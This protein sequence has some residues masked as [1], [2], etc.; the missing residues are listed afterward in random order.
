MA[1]HSLI[2]ILDYFVF[3]ILL[4]LNKVQRCIHLAHFDKSGTLIIILFEFLKDATEILLHIIWIIVGVGHQIVRWRDIVSRIVFVWVQIRRGTMSWLGLREDF[5]RNWLRCRTHTIW[6]DVR[7][8]LHMVLS[9]YFF[10]L[11]LTSLG[12]HRVVTW[13]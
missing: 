8:S 13:L 12:S 3:F 4:V 7:I 11:E 2:K 6:A 5:N 9:G 1:F 10:W